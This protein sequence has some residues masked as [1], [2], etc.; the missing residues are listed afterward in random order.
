V[1]VAAVKLPKYGP[2][3]QT[4]DANLT[5]FQSIEHSEMYVRLLETWLW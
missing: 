5:R 1:W 3:E 4:F 2:V